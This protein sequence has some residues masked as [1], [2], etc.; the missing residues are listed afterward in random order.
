MQNARL[1]LKS[2]KA[3]MHMNF[4]VRSI[5]N[6]KRLERQAAAK[7]RE[8][9]IPGLTGDKRREMVK[10]AVSEYRKHGVKISEYLGFHFYE[11]DDAERRTYI[12]DWERI[13]YTVRMNDPA[14]TRTFEN[15]YL[16]YQKFKKYYGRE[17]I[18]CSGEK[19][20]AQFEAFAQKFGS[21]MIKPIDASFGAGIQIL[22]E[23]AADTYDR[24]MKEYPEGFLG[25]ELIVQ[26]PFMAKF[27]P[28][29]VNSCRI[30]TIRF[31]DETIVIHPRFRLG[32][33]GS[34]VDNIS[35]GG[36]FCNLD[37]ETGRIVYATDYKSAVYEKHPDTGEQ[38]L[39]MTL[40]R[41]DECLAFVKEL[42]QVVP[43]NRYT[44]WDVVLTRKG[45]VMIE[46]N[47]RGQ[48]GWQYSD[49]GGARPEI[50]GYLKRLNRK[51]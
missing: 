7:I 43:D 17:M 19:D 1:S 49:E 36:L 50:D 11:K 27:H 18:L 16:A 28:S 24:L 30:I 20:K 34:I 4:F 44:A 47:C 21:F 45:W 51:Y 14:N 31:D 48:F 25:E 10:D 3:F 26:N 13:G 15:K 38:L 42:A 12:P 39:G 9:G 46:G 6:K 37:P 32:R 41:W 40:P 23:A 5:T 33:G 35:A 8:A 22:K 29:S 2:N